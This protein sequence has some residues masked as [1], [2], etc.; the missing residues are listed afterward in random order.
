MPETVYTSTVHI[1][2]LGV[3]YNQA[4]LPAESEP[5]L[6]GL[7]GGIAEHYRITPDMATPRAATLDYIVASAGGCLTGTFGGM[8]AA[9]KVSFGTGGLSADVRG[10]IER[11]EDNVLVIKR[12]HVVYHLATTGEDRE[13]VDR[14]YGLHANKCPVYRSLTPGITITTELDWSELTKEMG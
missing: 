9:R 3:P 2:H 5:V 4:V 8:L 7:H 6:F 13:K 1:N 11:E 10:E 14:A 12:I